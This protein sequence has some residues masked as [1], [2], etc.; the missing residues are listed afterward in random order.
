MAKPAILVVDDDVQVLR[1]L[2]HDLRHKY[3]G[4][5]RIVRSASADAAVDAL[6]QLKLRNEPVVL[7]LSD[8]RMPGVTGIEFL[9]Q[10]IMIYPDVKRALLTAYADTDA[11]IRAINT[12]KIDYYLLKPWEPPEEK[13]YPIVDDLLD[14]WQASYRP[15]FDGIRVIGHRW[16]AEGHQLKDFLAR[17]Q[18]PYRWMDVEADVE[19]LHLIEFASADLA[20]LPVVLFSDGKI[21]VKPT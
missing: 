13:L 14:D 11:A 21:L 20:R 9:E 8:Q 15:G 1:A 4:T 10:A 6:R 16:S 5:Y 7:I 3:G 19:A 18:V 12:V 2:E 17:N